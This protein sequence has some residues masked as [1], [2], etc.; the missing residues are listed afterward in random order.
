[1]KEFILT[2][3]Y[4]TIEEMINSDEM[5]IYIEELKTS[6]V[7]EYAIVSRTQKRY[8]INGNKIENFVKNPFIVEEIAANEPVIEKNVLEENKMKYCEVESA[9][10]KVVYDIIKQTNAKCFEEIEALKI[11]HENE[12]SNLKEEYENQLINVKESARTEAKAEILAKLGE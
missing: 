7:E 5:A 9:I 2:Q 6:K 10:D 8:D 1:M 11:A 4:A 12:I 3:S